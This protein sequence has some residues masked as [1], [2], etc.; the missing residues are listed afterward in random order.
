M[1]NSTEDRLLEFSKS[2]IVLTQ[3][4]S[5]GSDK[6]LKPAKVII[7]LPSSLPEYTLG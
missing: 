1:G 2:G 4:V 5:L 3:I 7:A 6:T